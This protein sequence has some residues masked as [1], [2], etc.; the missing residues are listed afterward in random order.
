MADHRY[1]RLVVRVEANAVVV[2]RETGRGSLPTERYET[3]DER[4]ALNANGV[5][6]HL[7]RNGPISGAAL[8][9]AIRTALYRNETRTVYE[10]GNAETIAYVRECRKATT[11]PQ[12]PENAGRTTTRQGRIQGYEH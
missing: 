9:K 10:T 8:I 7:D 5:I 11:A 1:R 12:R 2:E 3:E 6:G 4:S